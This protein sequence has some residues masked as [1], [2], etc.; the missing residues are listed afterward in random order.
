MSDDEP[1]SKTPLKIVVFD[2]DETLGC[3]TEVGMFWDVLNH[4]L[5]V[6]PTVNTFYNILD[7]FP[8]FLRPHIFLILQY[9]IDQRSQGKCHQL[10]IYTNNQGPRSWVKLISDYFNYKLGVKVFDQIIAAFKVNGEIVEVKRTTQNKCVDD[11]F[12]CTQLSTDT[13]I[14]F[15]DDQYHPLM[16]QQNVFY[17]TVQPYY[18]SM[19][20]HEMA[21]QF[22]DNNFIKEPS[23]ITEFVH[24]VKTYMSRYSTYQVVLKAPADQEIDKIVSKKLLDYL[25]EFFNNDYQ[26]LQRVSHSAKNASS[27][28]TKKKNSERKRHSWP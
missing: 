4:L 18:F 14:F 17:I 1:K 15:L 5:N 20:F 13:E 9:V 23:S 24:Q 28:K 3:F 22:Y 8:N 27:K 10:M 11:L 19:P 2:L 16:D 21:A 26:K 25:E 7:L 6:P 12:N